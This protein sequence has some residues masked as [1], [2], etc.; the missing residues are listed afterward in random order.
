MSSKL[1]VSF[2]LCLAVGGCSLF[3]GDDAADRKSL[4]A[5]KAGVIDRSATDAWL[6]RYEPKLRDLLADGPALLER[7]DNVL[8]VTMPADFSFNVGRQPAMLR[9]AAL[10]SITK[11]A[12]LLEG[13]PQTA[14]LIL[15]HEDSSG[16]LESARR[17]SHQ[18]AQSVA[19]I[20]RLSGLRNDRMLLKGMGPDMPRAANDSK[21]GRALNR[22]VEILVTPQNTLT[23][24][25]ARYSRPQD[26]T[27]LAARQ[28]Q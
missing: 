21:E 1:L 2:A 17:L 28:G 8:V 3:G 5:A 10:P 6:D 23:A 12:K 15:G 16:D 11:V 26:A 13:D 18:R 22:R 27:S 25:L 19:S 4:E 9:P 20:F 14:V 7:R 24:L